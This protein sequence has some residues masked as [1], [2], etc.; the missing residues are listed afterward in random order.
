MFEEFNSVTFSYFWKN[1]YWNAGGFPD[2]VHLVNGKHLIRTT[3]IF[4]IDITKPLSAYCEIFK[5][6]I[7]AH[8][9]VPPKWKSGLIFLNIPDL[10]F[11]F[12]SN[13]LK[14]H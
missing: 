6:Y 11:I 2:G 13:L 5:S 8:F 4:G 9:I 14:N 7:G 12:T 10:N 1:V 3:S